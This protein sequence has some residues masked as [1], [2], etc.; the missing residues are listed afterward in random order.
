MGL[1]ETSTCDGNISQA[2]KLLDCQLPSPVSV[3]EHSS[4]AE[5]FS[6]SNSA[7]SISSGGKRS[8]PS[9]VSLHH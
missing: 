2:R 5:S 4:S 8:R 7:E 1:E 6:S 9:I 3:F